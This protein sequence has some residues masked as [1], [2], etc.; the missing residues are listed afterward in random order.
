VHY[1]PVHTMPYY[2]TLG[3]SWGQF[4]NAER[5][6]ARCLSLPMFPT[7]T[8]AEQEYVIEN[9]LTYNDK[10]RNLLGR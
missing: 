7:L 1:I 8:D 3:G 9:V 4:P 5:Y 10:S 6:Y 2:R